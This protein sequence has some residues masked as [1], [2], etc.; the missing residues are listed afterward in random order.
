M[1]F[2]LVHPLWVHLPAVAALA[3]FIGFVISAGS[4]PAESPVHFNFAGEPNRYGSPWESFGLT[5][6]LSVLFILISILLDELWARQEKTKSFNWL[7]LLDDIVVGALVGIDLGYLFYLQNNSESFDFPWV[8]L[9]TVTGAC[10][11]L[12]V[13]LDML[14]PYRPYSSSLVSGDSRTLAAEVTA[15]L[16]DDA[17]FVY[18]DYQNP[19]YVSFIAIGLPI[20]M[21]VAGIITVFSQIWVSVILFV[22]GILLV[23]PY[24]GQRTIV[25]RK[26]IK[27][28]WGIFGLRV[29]HLKIPEITTAEIHEFS[30]LKDFG[31]YG[32]RFNSEMTAYYLRG[33]RGVKFTMA[34]GK[35]YLIGSD[36]PEQLYAVVDSLVDT[37]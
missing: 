21:I 27:V 20:V 31:G 4:L 23:F 30:P 7:S 33:T 29:L 15:R 3:V 28:R 36:H 13:V 16:K 2:K 14:R 35:K 32:I 10:I 8:L 12:A 9:C 18:W 24:G 6:G 26:D 19:P 11:I 17:P 1:K 37:G 25:T 5:I 34:N 22:V